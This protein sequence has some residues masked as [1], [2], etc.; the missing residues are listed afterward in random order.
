MA[1]QGRF[2][3]SSTIE[4]GTLKRDCK[5]NIT[6]GLRALSLLVFIAI[7]TA[8]IIDL[9]TFQSIVAVSHP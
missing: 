3:Y 2:S 6:L 7:S 8:V 5:M 4:T 1:K 9:E